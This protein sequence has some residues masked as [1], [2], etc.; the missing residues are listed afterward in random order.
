[1]QKKNLRGEF[2]V[3]KQLKIIIG[4]MVLGCIHVMHLMKIYLSG[5]YFI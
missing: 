5:I 3:M 2:E 1:M 4:I